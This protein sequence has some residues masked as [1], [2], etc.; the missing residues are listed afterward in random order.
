MKEI[1]FSGRP[2]P[3]TVCK[4]M[5]WGYTKWRWVD[6]KYEDRN[7]GLDD[8]DFEDTNYLKWGAVRIGNDNECQPDFN[9]DSHIY[10]VPYNQNPE[11]INDSAFPLAGDIGGPLVCKSSNRGLD[12]VFGT[13]IESLTAKCAVYTKL[14]YFEDWI[15]E[16]M[17]WKKY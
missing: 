11:I 8:E 10:V 2:R 3:G 14:S 9:E 16:E 1:N 5:G 15:D 12:M 7:F 17:E 13:M 6:E 4:I